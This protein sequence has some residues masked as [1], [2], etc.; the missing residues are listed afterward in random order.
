[1]HLSKTARGRI[2]VLILCLFSFSLLPAC[3]SSAVETPSDIPAAPQEASK[4]S[5][6]AIVGNNKAAPKPGAAKKK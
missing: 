4:A 3:G 6:Q 2:C 1:M 5:Y